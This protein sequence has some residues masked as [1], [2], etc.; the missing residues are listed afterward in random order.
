MNGS[1]IAI[2]DIVSVLKEKGL[3]VSLSQPEGAAGLDTPLA[4]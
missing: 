4:G 2:G 1:G 3:F